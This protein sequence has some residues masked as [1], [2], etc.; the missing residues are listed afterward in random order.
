MRSAFLLVFAAILANTT[1]TQPFAGTPALSGPQNLAP[2]LAALTLRPTNDS[3]P[4]TCQPSTFLKIYGEQGK[5][6]NMTAM[7]SAP[8]GN[9][10]LAGRKGSGF[11]IAKMSPEGSFIWVRVTNTAP[12]ESDITEII[13]DSEGMIVGIGKKVSPFTTSTQ[14]FA[15]RYDPVSNLVLWAQ[16]FNSIQ[17]EGGGILEKSPGGNYLLYHT[18]RFINNGVR[19]GEVLELNRTSGQIVPTFARRY[20]QV[21]NQSIVTMLRHGDALYATGFID[22][23]QGFSLFRRMALTKLDANTGDVIWTR[24][25][26]SDW[27]ATAYFTGADLI[28]DD[29]SLLV[30]YRGNETSNT[31]IG[32]SNSIYLQKTTFDGEVIWAKKYQTNELPRDLVATPDGYIIW[33][34]VT[35]RILLKTDKQGNLLKSVLLSNSDYFSTA[36]TDFYTNQ[37]QQLGQHF[38]FASHTARSNQIGQYTT[39]VKTDINLDIEFACDITPYPVQDFSVPNPSNFPFQQLYGLG[40]AEQQPITLAFVAD[41]MTLHLSCPTCSDPPCLDKPDISFK[42]ESVGCDSAAFVSYSLCNTGKQTFT[43]HLRVGVY[44]SN[45]LTGAATLLD[46]FELINLNLPADSCQ[47]GTLNNLAYWGNHT[48][49]YTLAGIESGLA[50]PVNPDSFPYNGIAECDYTNNL[51]SIDFQYPPALPGPDL[52]PDLVICAGD[53]VT[54]NA[55]TGFVSY[56]WSNNLSTPAIPASTSGSYIVQA[57]DACGRIQPDTIVVTVLPQPSTTFL[58]IE[59]YPG[60]TV[61]LGGQN[62]TQSDTVSIV[63]STVFGCDSTVT[64]YLRQVLTNLDLVCPPGLVASIPASQSSVAVSYALPA[65]AT[66]CPDAGIS[67]ALLQGLPPDGLFPEGVTMVCYEASNQCG[68][69][70][71]CCFTVTAQHVA[72]ETACDVKM[73]PGS[74]VKYEL[75]DI[76]LDSLG[77]PHYRMRLTNNCASPLRF[78]RFQLPDGLVAKAPLDGTSYTAP[79]GNTYLV[80]NPNATPFHSIRFKSVSGA[81]NNGENDIFEYALPKQAQPLFIQVSAELADGSMTAAHINTFGCPIQAHQSTSREA[82]E[83]LP[84]SPVPTQTLQLQPNP[85]TGYLSVALPAMHEGAVRVFVS[86]AQGQLVLETSLSATNNRFSLDIPEGLADGLYYLRVMPAGKIPVSAK[87]VLARSKR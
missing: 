47:N 77:Y 42:I 1:F 74:C 78:A 62:Y 20:I 86:S 21:S 67:L 39:L 12:D 46:F 4:D 71:T 6:E 41:L 40:Q 64:Y 59:F 37:A 53:T 36:A 29:S 51:D 10:Y 45:P 31:P 48:R 26:L 38:I 33:G 54:L 73:P 22:V 75:L 11:A 7:C 25:G 3:A 68:I 14:S 76:R 8:D 27:P 50:T 85:T 58:T 87:F 23:A 17:P 55:G 65:A 32:Q 35:K 19:Y 57:T 5:Q 60:D 66:D 70:D 18:V 63:T 56:H 61:T 52:G 16:Q 43:G 69:R 2:Q 49:V 82:L 81:L 28:E 34:G 9:L 44:D 80:R 15:F 30:L 79:G 24:F 72:D 84:D 83:V 13:V